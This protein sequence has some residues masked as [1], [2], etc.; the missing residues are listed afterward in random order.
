MIIESKA[1]VINSFKYG[2]F[3]LITRCFTLKNGLQSFLLKGILKSKQGG[4]RKSQF[5]PLT[6]LKLIYN[7]KNNG[8]LQFIKEAKAYNIYKSIPNKISKKTLVIFLSDILKNILKDNGPNESLY[9]FIEISLNILDNSEKIK[10][11]HIIF[12]IKLSKFLGFF[13]N[14]KTKG[15][16]FNIEKGHFTNNHD[17][18]SGE[19][20]FDVKLFKN[21]LGMNFGDVEGINITKTSRNQLIEFLIEYYKF[22]INGFKRP[23]SL[24]IL[25]ELFK[26]P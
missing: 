23:K 9:V 11:Y 14:S 7:F 25:N 12:M 13:P 6:Q 21:L 19:N 2:E 18:A 26:N 15:D 20:N 4:V 17:L 1:I 16:F 10:Y 24:D 3:G 22:H 8:N 5:E